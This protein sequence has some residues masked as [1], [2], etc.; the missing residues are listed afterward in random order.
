VAAAAA[1]VDAAPGRAASARMRK[2][3]PAWP[4][5]RA[6]RLEIK[7]VAIAQPPL[8]CH[9][10]GISSNEVQSVYNKIV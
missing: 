10:S 7:R 6:A 2:T 5:A 3:I 8:R 4:T 1:E 9:A